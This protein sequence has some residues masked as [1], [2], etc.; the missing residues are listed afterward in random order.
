MS[1]EQL[2]WSKEVNLAEENGELMPHHESV[3]HNEYQEHRRYCE[4]NRIPKKKFREFYKELTSRSPGSISS[5][6]SDITSVSRQNN[7]RYHS[8]SSNF[9]TASSN[10]SISI[11]SSI[12]SV[13]LSVE[14]RIIDEDDYLRHIQNASDEYIRNRN[15][16]LSTADNRSLSPDARILSG[17]TGNNTVEN[18]TNQHIEPQVTII[19][20]DDDVSICSIGTSSCSSNPSSLTNNTQQ[21]K[22][23]LSSKTTKTGEKFIDGEVDILK[24][25]EMETK[26]EIL[27]SE[28][29]IKQNTALMSLEKEQLELNKKQ[30][31]IRKLESESHKQELENFKSER[32]KQIAI[33]E[34]EYTIEELNSKI[35][36]LRKKNEINGE[37]VNLS[38][39]LQTLEAK[40]LGKPF[41]SNSLQLVNNLLH[42]IVEDYGIEGTIK[43]HV[44]K[45][46][47]DMYLKSLEKTKINLTRKSIRKLNKQNKIISGEVDGK[48]VGAFKDAVQTVTSALTLSPTK[49]KPITKQKN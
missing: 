1:Q 43:P 48:I 25:N 30:Q 35:S 32:N 49:L 37:T 7:K 47:Y 16:T 12:I 4:R 10:S 39:I 21:N 2:H 29:I 8:N 46:V 23:V 26:N 38:T 24:K 13:K 14:G 22:L 34:A 45:T 31:E 6:L 3:F 36:K 11:V 33:L 42:N 20:K 18:E 27:E 9:S 28:L 41:T 15:R 19:E 5:N 17:T 44:I 40:M